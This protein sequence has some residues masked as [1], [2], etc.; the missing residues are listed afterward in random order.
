MIDCTLLLSMDDWGDFSSSVPKHST[1]SLI[2]YLD[3]SVKYLSRAH[4]KSTKNS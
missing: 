1:F 2:Q 3:I 4:Y